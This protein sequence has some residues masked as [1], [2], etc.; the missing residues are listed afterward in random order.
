[1]ARLSNPTALIAAGLALALA[2]GLSAREPIDSHNSLADIIRG[3]QPKLVKIYGAGG[4][5][6][7]EAY[8]SG[9]FISPEGHILTVW[10]YVLDTDVVLAVLHDGTRYQATLVGADPKLEIAVLKI[11]VQH[12][13]YFD[14]HS[15]VEPD[16]GSWVLAFSNIFG[17]ATG[18][19]MPS[20]LHG[21]VSAKTE[22]QARRGA[23]T[24]PY[25]GP[26]LVLDAITNNPGAAG[27]ALTD[28]S[29][30]FVGL[31]GKELRN[32][33]TNTW[34][35]YAIPAGELTASVEAILA[36]RAPTSR[37][38]SSTPRPA[39]PM[40]LEELGLV[41][42]PEVLPKTPPFIESVRPGSPA[43]EAGLAPDD[44]ILFVNDHLVPSC[45][46]VREELSYIDR[47][48]PVRLTVQREQDLIE[49]TLRLP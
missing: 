39:S 35:N 22:L 9:F 16:V 40:S 33:L 28:A 12:A 38:D 27:G 20:V 19:E 18:D 29:G 45:A 7:L 23:F 36:G 17:V 1:M 30:R 10:S 31:L 46:A 13:D 24:I 4:L 43:A 42:V 44:L 34:I 37:G 41:L 3:V 26:V 2:T 49:V 25:Q 14:L 47:I 6:G 5:R 8:Q 21:T 48:D 32:D 11:D 15:A